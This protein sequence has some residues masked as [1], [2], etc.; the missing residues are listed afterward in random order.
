[1]VPIADGSWRPCGDIR[2]LNYVT[3]LDHYPIPHIQDFYTHLAGAT[4]FSK[5]DLVRGYH[6][7]PVHPQDIP[8]A[9]VITSFWLFEF[10]RMSFGLKGA[11]QTFQLMMDSVLRDMPFLFVYLAAKEQ[12]SHLSLL[13]ECLNEHRLIV[14][15]AK[16]QF[17]W[18]AIEFLGNHVT[19]QEVIRLP[20]KVKPLQEFLGMVNLYDRFI[21]WAAHRMS[22]L[23]EALKGKKVKAFRLL[24]TL[25]LLSPALPC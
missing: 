21:P 5:V 10:L 20:A 24:R 1:M 9:A 15:P 23:Y 16:C 4:I 13:F 22:P 17:G 11:A 19:P 18:A 2:Y 6:Q 25:K 3:T 8:K 12:L 7:L 14:N